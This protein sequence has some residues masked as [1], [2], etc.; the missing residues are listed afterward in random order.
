MSSDCAAIRQIDFYT[1]EASEELLAERG[2]YIEKVLIP[3]L[4]SGLQNTARWL[5]EAPDDEEMKT[6]HEAY[7]RGCNFFQN[8]I[9]EGQ[10]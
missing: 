2:Q 8:R 3:W 9:N 5:S 1:T 4:N 10:A 6:L 7:K